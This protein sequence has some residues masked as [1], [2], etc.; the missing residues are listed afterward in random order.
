VISPSDKTGSC[1]D[2]AE[3]PTGSGR[4][5]DMAFLDATLCRCNDSAHRNQRENCRTLTDSFR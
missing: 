1:F 2:S 5:F 4:I 3:K